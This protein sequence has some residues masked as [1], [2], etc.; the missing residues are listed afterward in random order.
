MS[1]A[2]QLWGDL[3]PYCEQEGWTRALRWNC[4]ERCP[5]GRRGSRESFENF[6][7]GG[8]LKAYGIHRYKIPSIM[9]PGFNL[10]TSRDGEL[11]TFLGEL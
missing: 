11:I 4:E 6:R 2:P 5:D 1:S 3:Q 9:S 7:A 10:A 8:T